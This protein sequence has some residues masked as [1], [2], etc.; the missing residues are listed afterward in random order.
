MSKLKE[1]ITLETAFGIYKV[2]ELLGEG[3]A[4]RVYGGVGSDNTRVALKVLTSDKATVDK[5][6][7]FRNEIAFL[8][9]NKHRNVVS[10]LD[11]G[12]ASGSKIA[13]PFYVMHRYDE[14][15]R[16]LI[17]A[18]IAPER[19][20]SLYSQILDGVEAAHLQGVVH[21]DLKPEN[22]LHDKTNTRLAIAD[23]GIASF[24]EDIIATL[25]ETA[26]TQRLANFVYAAPEQRIPGGHI[27]PTADIY[28][29]GLILNEMFTGVPPH[30]TNYKTIG[31]V[32]KELSFLDPIITEMLRQT[33]A[34]RPSSIAAIKEMI[35]KYK[36]EAVSLQRL[37]AIDRTVIKVS[38][39]DEP[40]A[41][42][43]PR[44]IN[45]EWNNNTLTLTLDRPVNLA[46]VRALQNMGNYTSLVGKEPAMFRFQ[47][48]KAVVE[49]R[50]EQEAQQ[51][52]IYFKAWLPRATQ[53]LKQMLE[54]EARQNEAQQKEQLRQQRLA[55]EQRLHI[56][57]NLKI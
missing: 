26:A 46:W 28:A 11:H 16:H 15:L 38:D 39:I 40:L 8:A 23:F 55:E 49:A 18:G 43:P 48:N 57:R 20:L 19:V 4:G 35:Q 37:S 12:V 24:T 54:Q 6:Q 13:G 32:S 1:P 5:R 34:E 17:Q 41:Y 36:A 31:S 14:N 30:G 53:V 45:A 29:L 7:R 22:I 10:V 25:V 51:I 2:D 56:N 44:L 52:I 33:P 3:G 47:G 27:T 21:R 42:E 9:R 50:G